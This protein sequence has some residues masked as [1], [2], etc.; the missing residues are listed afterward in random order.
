MDGQARGYKPPAVVVQRAWFNATL[1]SRWFI[2]VGIVALL[3]L[4]VTLEVTALSVA[5]EREAGTFDQLLVTPMTPFEILVGKSLPGLI[6][7][8]IEATVVIT[9]VVYWFHVP[10]RGSLPALYLGLLIFLLSAVG[11]GLMIS[12][13]SITQQQGLMGAFLFL[14]PAVIL[15]GFATPIENMPE[16]VQYLTYLNPMRYFL[17]IVRSVFLQGASFDL[18]WSQ[19]WPMA[20]IGLTTLTT[21]A[22]M[23]RKRM[24]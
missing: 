3:N 2:I 13:L 9:M 6:I 7:G 18:L 20:L 17:I 4:V 12:A 19:Y 10:L 16:L 24:Y 15:S 23:F 5:R 11:I 1:D 21:A 14:V 8:V 22:L